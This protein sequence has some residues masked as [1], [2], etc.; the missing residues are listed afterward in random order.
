MTEAALK[1][2][3][4]K[5]PIEPVT[6]I[7]A[8]VTSNPKEALL[9]APAALVS[10]LYRAAGVF[11]EDASCTI[12]ELEPRFEPQAF[13]AGQGFGTEFWFRDKRG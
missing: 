5:A 7:T 4:T 11:R 12:T 3:G 2:V 8:A 6:F 1:R 13:R 10:D 9:R